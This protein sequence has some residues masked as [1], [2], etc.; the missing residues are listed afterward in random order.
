MTT[1]LHSQAEVISAQEASCIPKRGTQTFGLGH[2]F[3]GGAG[4]AERGLEISTFAVVDVTH[5]W[6]FTL[7]V[8]QTPP[9]CAM[10]TQQEQATTLG[11]FSVQQRRAHHQRLPAWVASHAVDG[12]LA[13]KK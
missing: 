7:A 5:R 4:R 13:T 1:A 12:Y 10:A 8:A 6:A 9:P 2:F 11:D 3:N